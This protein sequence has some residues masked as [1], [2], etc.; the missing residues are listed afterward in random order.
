MIVL[1]AVTYKLISMIV[2]N[3]ITYQ[4][5]SVIVFNA[6]TYKLQSMLVGLQHFLCGSIFTKDQV[7]NI[8][9]MKPNKRPNS[10]KLERCL[11]ANGHVCVCV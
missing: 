1:N 6:V 2:F 8:V 10:L 4:F 9:R 3:A 7:V 5:Q 11:F